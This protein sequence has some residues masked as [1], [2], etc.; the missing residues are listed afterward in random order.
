[1]CSSDLAFFGPTWYHFSKTGHFINSIHFWS[2]QIFFLSLI[3]HLITKYFIAA[4]RDGRF[5]TWLFGML[6]FA[7]AVFSGLSGYLIQTDYDSQWIAVQA[8]DAF[9]ALGVGAF[10]NLMDTGQMLTL[11]MVFFPVI[12]V[13]FA[14]IHL[15]FI[16]RDSPVKPIETKGGK[17]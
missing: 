8:K 3:A 11:H 9:N 10:I 14:L 17:K 6:A 7:V 12:L 5:K 13:L 16:R 15:Y 2:V 1:M 4:W